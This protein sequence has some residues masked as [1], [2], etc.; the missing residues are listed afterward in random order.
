[1]LTK[2]SWIELYIDETLVVPV[3]RQR[4][5]RHFPGIKFRMQV[6][7]LRL[8][9]DRRGLNGD[10]ISYLPEFEGY[11]LAPHRVGGDR[12]IDPCEGAETAGGDLEL[13][14]ARYE[15]GEDIVA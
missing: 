9:D 14:D 2:A 13:V 7:L 10:G 3:A 6:R 11:V 12:D 15:A 1:M 8:E 5:V 4:K